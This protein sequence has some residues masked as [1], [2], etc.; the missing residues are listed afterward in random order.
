[1]ERNVAGSIYLGFF[2]SLFFLLRCSSWFVVFL[3][4]VFVIFYIIW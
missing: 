2:A 1:M 4:S 3:V